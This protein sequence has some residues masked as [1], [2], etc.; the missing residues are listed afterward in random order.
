[1]PPYPLRFRPLIKQRIWGGNRLRTLLGKPA[2]EQNSDA[3]SWEVVDHGDDQSIVQ[4]G[5]LAGKALADLVR[6]HATWLLGKEA[7]GA[8]FPLL[9]KYLD[10]NRVLSVQVHPDDTY[11]ARMDPPDLGKTEAWYVVAAEPDSLIYAGLKRGVGRQELAK[12]VAEGQTDSVLH[13]FHP[14]AGDCVFIPAGTVHALGEGLVIAEIQQSSDTT[15]R[16][17][18]WNRVGDDGQP[19][20]L[21]IERS[22]D[23]SDY[24]A[25]PIAPRHADRSKTGWQSL[26]R[27]DKFV[28]RSLERGEAEIAGDDQ[29]HLLTC[30]RGGA[31][32]RWPSQTLSLRRGES[33]LLPAAMPSCNV[34]LQ[35][36]D[37]TLLAADPGVTDSV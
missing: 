21:H 8:A 9:L 4:N 15:F 31:T 30:P 37:S 18:D 6:Q 24:V 19:R 23:V 10:C 14:A 26:V 33:V 25:G 35:D 3:E 29:F 34:T 36:G 2:T 11:A 16:L 7:T 22:L 27:C 32:L 5:P 17:F 28:L 20:P 1:M 13:S 12:A